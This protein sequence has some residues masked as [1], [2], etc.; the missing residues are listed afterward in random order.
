MKRITLIPGDGIGP[1]VANAM[2]RCVDALN[3]GIVWDVQEAGSQVYAKEGDPLPPRILESIKK[4]K[5]AIKGPITTPIGTGFRSVNVRLRQSLEL[6]ACVRPC[7]LYEGTP[8][9][10]DKVNLII[11]REN[12]EDLYSGIEYDIGEKDTKNLIA[13]IRRE[14]KVNL[15]LDTAISIKPISKRRSQAIIEF[16]FKYALQ[17]KRGK[18]AAIHK[19]NIMKCTDGLFLRTAQQIAKKYPKIKFEQFIVDNACMQLVTNPSKFDVLVLPN[20]YGDIISDLCSAFTGGLG[21]APGANIGKHFAVFEA[22]HGSVP[23][24][25]GL[26]I[27]NPC[28]MI[29]SAVL[30]LHYI[31]KHKHALCLE[32]AVARVIRKG[33][34]ITYDLR[35][36]RDKKKAASTS[37][38]TN[39]ILKELQ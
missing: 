28:A 9:R 13:K 1:E 33:K 30:M 12:M 32:K 15:G 26:D 17:H 38:M 29:L 39:A 3:L 19:A 5:V 18:V 35:K 11:V 6:Y 37:Q 34:N 22:T 20:L 31:G 2:R 23:K 21:M 24:Y 14:K 36:D 4:N 8:S 7:V 10:Y 25:A 16:A 27:V